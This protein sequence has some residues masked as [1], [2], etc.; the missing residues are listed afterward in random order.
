MAHGRKEL[1]FRLAG[2]IGEH[3]SG[4]ELRLRRFDFLQMLIDQCTDDSKA[5]NQEDHGGQRNRE[6]DDDQRV[7][8]NVDARIG[9]ER[10]PGHGDEMGSQNSCGEQHAPYDASAYVRRQLRARE[11]RRTEACAGE[12]GGFEIEDVPI[13][14]RL[15]GYSGHTRE[16]HRADRKADDGAAERHLLRS[17][18][19]IEA[20]TASQ[21]RDQSGNHRHADVVGHRH[22]RLVGEHHDRMCRPRAAA[23]DDRGGDHPRIAGPVRI[24]ARHH[25]EGRV[26]RKEAHQNREHDKAR[27]VVID[28]R[29]VEPL[30]RVRSVDRDRFTF[31]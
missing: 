2:G 12:H 9:Y 4:F 26:A 8:R 11:C 20:D 13:N 31:C 6:P 24:E 29:V 25:G 19:D 17:A 3:E 14:M 16:V 30:H 28:D 10:A 15:E 1:G 22:A 18:R 7:L 23:C 21:H 27:I 5:H